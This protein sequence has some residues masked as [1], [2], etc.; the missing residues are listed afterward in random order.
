VVNGL[1]LLDAGDAYKPSTEEIY[2]MVRPI[3]RGTSLPNCAE[4]A[5]AGYRA[6]DSTSRRTTG[7][8]KGILDFAERI[9]PRAADLWVQASLDQR[10]R[11]QQLFC[12]DRIASTEIASLEPGATAPVFSYL[13]EIRTGNE[14]WVDQTC[15]SWN[16]IANWLRHLAV[17]R[18][19]S[20][21]SRLVPHP[22]ARNYSNSTEVSGPVDITYRPSGFTRPSVHTSRRSGSE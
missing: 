8:P 15:A 19:A 13:Q 21:S 6:L 12:P 1:S 3:D 4:A 20:H 11:F 14:G 9:L 22:S 18:N 16:P 17:E 7:T 10:Q 5:N 2:V